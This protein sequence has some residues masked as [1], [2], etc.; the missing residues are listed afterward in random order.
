MKKVFLFI[1]PFLIAFLVF[2]I[3]VFVLNKNSN[4]GALQ[5]TSGSVVSNVYINGKLMGQTPFCKCPPKDMLP[6]GEYTIRLVPQVQGFTPFEEKVTVSN[7]VLTAVDRTFGMAGASEGVVISL[8]PLSNNAGV[9]L[10]VVSI[11]D[12]ADVYVDK[13]KKGVTPLLL[14]DITDSDHEI[15]LEKDGYAQKSVRIKTVRGYKLSAIVY[16]GVSMLLP[17][18]NPS[19]FPATS[20]A[21]LARV[22]ILTTP[23]GFLR[24]RKEPSSESA[25]IAQ[26]K[27]GEEYD[28]LEEK[29]GWYLIKLSDGSGWISA[30]YATKK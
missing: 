11:P 27:P 13:N 24:V 25:Q 23:T 9:E 10:L 18:L 2:G 6:V 30:D 16:M 22:T 20:S 3:F 12:K 5:V 7:A 1:L 28:V 17:S 15:R 29:E 8:L 19:S 4:K 26:V 14:K 21:T